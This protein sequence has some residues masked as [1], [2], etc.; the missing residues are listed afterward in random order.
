MEG[1]KIS[2]VVLAMAGLLTACGSRVWGDDSEIS[3]ALAFGEAEEVYKDWAGSEYLG[4]YYSVHV[5]EMWEDHSV[6]W[7]T[8]Y[9]SV[10]FDKV[11][12]K[13]MVGLA[14]SE[15]EVYTLEEW[16]NSS[17]YPSLDD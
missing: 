15:F 5:S 16:R 9:V 7:S 13:D 1:R 3:T 10:N 12:W 8:F 11:L 6:S 17:Y 2:F 4:E 14:D